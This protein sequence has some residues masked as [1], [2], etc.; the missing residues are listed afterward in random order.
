MIKANLKKSVLISLWLGFLTFPILV[1]QVNTI[2]KTIIWNWQNLFYMIIASYILSFLWNMAIDRRALG[3]KK[4]NLFTTYTEK[5]RTIFNERLVVRNTS[6]ALVTLFIMLFP[7]FSSLYQVSIMN[8]ALMYVMLGLGLNIVVGLGGILNLGYIA[9]FLMG[10]YSYAL[11][12]QHFGLNFW[13]ALPI[14]GLISCIF[15]IL[16][17][18]P[19]LRLR[20]DY[21]AIVTLAFGEITRIVIENWGSLTGGPSGI[22]SIPRPKIPGITLNLMNTTRLVFFIMILLSALTIIITIRLKDSR[23]GR[24]LIAMREDEIACQAMGINTTKMKVTAFALGAVFAGVAGVVFAANTTFINP[25]SFTIWESVI[26]LCIV[27]LGGMGS[28]PGVIFAALVLKL[29]PEYLR[30]FS[31]Y[32]MLVFGA[33]MVIMMV[34]KPDGLIPER[35]KHYTFGETK[36]PSSSAGSKQAKEEN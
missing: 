29:L 25:A 33:L 28:I 11:L 21:L 22:R 36:T 15:G 8:T 4:K 24:A 35:R 3:I 7:F 6:L 30:A 18:I 26:V 12:N 9:F 13:F 10:S 34:F 2:E 32:R 31:S 17:S 16:I 27:V 5:V 1:I 20:G 14:G 19:V 23:I